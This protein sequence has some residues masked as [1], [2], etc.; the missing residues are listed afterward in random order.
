MRSRSPSTAES[1]RPATRNAK[2]GST[3]N[4]TAPICQQVDA[5]RQEQP[6]PRED[7]SQSCRQ[8]L[9]FGFRSL[10]DAG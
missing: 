9:E 2:V 5:Y 1:L 8:N 6:V 7:L 4:R 10:A 3:V